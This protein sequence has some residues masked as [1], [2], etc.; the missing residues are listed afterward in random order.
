MLMMPYDYTSDKAGI[1][2]I[3]AFD[4]Y[5]SFHV[6]MLSGLES[7][8]GTNLKGE[9][10]LVELAAKIRQL[11]TWRY[12]TRNVRPRTRRSLRKHTKLGE[13]NIKLIFNMNARTF[14][15][16][17]TLRGFMTCNSNHLKIS[18]LFPPLKQYVTKTN[19]S[20]VGTIFEDV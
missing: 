8:I 9:S 20:I 17:R 11:G 14:N 19:L 12:M 16:C 15:L 3:D 13:L 18:A 2:V 5:T 1:M 4:D 10:E 6:L 7:M